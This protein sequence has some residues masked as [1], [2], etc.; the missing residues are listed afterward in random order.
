MPFMVQIG[1]PQ[2]SIHQGQ[3]VL[4]S[5]PDGQINWPSER[6]L[7]FLDTRVVSSWTVYA[8]GE[9]W[10]LLNGGP[11]TYYAARIFLTNHSF[12]TEAG[13]IPPRTLGFTIS[14]WIYGGMHEDLDITNNSMKP[15]KFQL[16]IAIRCDFADLFEVKSGNI[17]RRG[18]ITT[19][20]SQARQ[21]LCTIYCNGDF[22]RSVAITAKR[23]PKEAVY[24]NGRLSFEVALD[25]GEA[26]HTC[27]F[28][29][30]TDNNKHSAP[31]RNCIEHH[32]TSRHAE[33]MADWLRT[34]AKIQ[35]SNEEFYR[36][37]RRALEDMAALRLP[38]EGTDHT[39]FVPAA[40][41]PWF[42]APFGRDSLIVS[43]QNMLIHPE[44]ARGSLDILGSLQAKE[45]D[46]YRDAEPGKIFHELRYGELAHF[47]L[48]P[49]TP[50]YGTADAT[51][52]YL[53]TLH[54]AWRAT[55][56][57][58]LLE[59]HLEAVEGCLSWI[60]NYGDRDGDGFQEYQTRSPAGYE[61]MAWKD[62]GDSVVYPDGSLVKGPK[63]LYCGAILKPTS[64]R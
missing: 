45:D 12:A 64:I 43:L 3:T 14:R 1:P 48:I 30:L 50:Y 17:V 57:Q 54:A 40:G 63:A 29:T 34:V 46:P 23:F 33:T 32:P 20:W 24:A 8:N 41:L 47:K 18:R 39:V 52:L 35:T 26:W 9:P 25:P 61:N 36:L 6:G 59:R 28:Y 5:E 13:I 4:I 27:L 16:E 19:E 51:P 37:F 31:P 7:Y 38:I 58:T 15:T 44:F 42:I 10:E 60:D 53:I 55:G 11:I 49:H 56:D 22:S 2:I 62:S 21:K